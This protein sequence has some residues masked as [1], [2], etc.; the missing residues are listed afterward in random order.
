MLALGVFTGVPFP[1]SA[2]GGV[3][4]IYR[5]WDAANKKVVEETRTY[6][7]YTELSARS[8]DTLSEGV[9]VVSQSTKVSSRLY[10]ESGTV[11]LI[12]CDG[13]TLTAEKGIRVPEGSTLIIYGQSKDSGKL[14]ANSPKY[15]AA[16]GRG[17]GGDKDGS[18]YLSDDVKVC[19]GTAKKEGDE[20]KF[21]VTG[22]AAANDRVNA[23]RKNKMIMIDRCEHEK[24]EWRYETAVQHGKYCTV[25][26]G[27]LNQKRHR[28]ELLS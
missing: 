4:F 5:T 10:V 27:D 11:E 25:C 19:I 12:L 3:S 22:T 2:A 13:T 28:R 18:L 16:I 17:N 20:Y 7:D 23:C 1:V 26:S 6:D 15:D 8:S 21:E 24:T 14:V 9:Y